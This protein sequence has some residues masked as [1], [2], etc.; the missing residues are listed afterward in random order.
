MNH[1]EKMP[2]SLVI[3]KKVGRFSERR[4]RAQKI[5]LTGTPEVREWLNSFTR[6]HWYFYQCRETKDL[7]IA[8]YDKDDAMLFKLTWGGS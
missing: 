6:G 3:K 7:M 4:N 8:F 2:S 1:S 5:S